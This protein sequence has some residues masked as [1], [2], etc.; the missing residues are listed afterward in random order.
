M[1]SRAAVWLPVLAAIGG[2][3]CTCGSGHGVAS[4]PPPDPPASARPIGATAPAPDLSPAAHAALDRRI[5]EARKGG[6]D[7][8][9]FLAPTEAESAAYGAWVTAAVRAAR[10]AAKPPSEAPDGF[11]IEVIEEGALWLLAE[12]PQR[13]RGAGAVAIRVGAARELVVEAPH[14]FFDAKTLPI[15]R[16]VFDRQ[17]ARALVVN[18][19]HR[20]RE[21][22]A[23]GDDRA[24]GG[25]EGPDAPV[26]SDVAHATRSFFLAAHDALVASG[27][28][29]PAIQVH[30]FGDAT[31]PGVSVIVSAAGTR[32]DAR[33]AATAL[34]ALLGDRAVRVS[35]D[36]IGVLAGLTN[37]Q[38]RS[39][40]RAGA[41][42]LHVELSRTARDRLAADPD[43]CAG[44]AAA[45]APPGGAGG[46][47]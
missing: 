38:A 31:A 34:R 7:A 5:D 25:D 16:T 19:A 17:R 30:G 40:A 33:G 22:L 11:A 8:V 15:A 43:L 4:S 20:Y 9:A 3:G 45:V 26:Q 18:T 29:L 23:A 47:P 35:P 46:A 32:A 14:T 36:E 24:G 21:R 27:P 41:P 39:S 13:R 2:S 28:G 44:F 10:G 6:R 12:R 1:T 37:V 42:F